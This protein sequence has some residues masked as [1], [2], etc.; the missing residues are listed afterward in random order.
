VSDDQV[1]WQDRP[2][3]KM[4]TRGETMALD[5]LLKKRVEVFKPAF[6]GRHLID[7]MAVPLAGF[8]GIW[9]P[10]AVEVKTKRRRLNWEDTGIDL[11][12][13]ARYQAIGK[14]MPVLMVF[15]DAL[16]RAIYGNFLHRLER[17]LYARAADLNYSFPLLFDYPSEFGGI[18]FWP[19][20]FM[21]PFRRLDEKE[22]KALE[23]FNRRNSRYGHEVDL[24]PFS[25]P[26]F[27]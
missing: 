27:L 13:L 3:V 4:G 15:C 17:Q 22:C 10:F 18:R 12:L 9:R 21:I 19:L 1:K 14:T 25:N 20:D 24:V 5:F 23:E 6:E 2:Q 11:H 8:L 7:Y 26:G 16:Q